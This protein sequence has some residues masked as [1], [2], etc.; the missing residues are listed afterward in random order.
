M[1]MKWKIGIVL[2][3]AL[4]I[5]A[6]NFQFGGLALGPGN[7]SDMPW[8][9]QFIATEWSLLHAAGVI[10]LI[11]FDWFEH[12]G[13]APAH[14]IHKSWSLPPAYLSPHRETAAVLFSGGYITTALLLFVIL[15]VFRRFLHGKRKRSIEAGDVPRYPR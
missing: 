9:L 13:A 1:N 10:I 11:V 15:W 6:V 5:E 3:A 7:F 2:L 4:V 14:A 8:Y 12:F